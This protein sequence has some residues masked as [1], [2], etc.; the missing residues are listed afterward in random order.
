MYEAIFRKYLKWLTCSK[1]TLLTI[2]LLLI[3]SRPLNTINFDFGINMTKLPSLIIS[4]NLWILRKAFHIARIEGIWYLALKVDWKEAVYYEDRVKDKQITLIMTN[5]C[6]C[7]QN[8]HNVSQQ[9]ILLKPGHFIRYGYLK[10][11]F[12]TTLFDTA[13]M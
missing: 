8:V 5:Y 3:G 13:E 10:W 2:I 11:L 1:I 12:E 4:I 9:H 7:L 6:H